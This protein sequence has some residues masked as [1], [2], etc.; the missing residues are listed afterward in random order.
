VGSKIH[1]SQSASAS[2]NE[3]H[4][5]VSLALAP[6]GYE[7]TREPSAT[8]AFRGLAHVEFCGATELFPPGTE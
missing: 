6:N 8:S 5:P 3:Q 4:D 7:G 2:H 1:T